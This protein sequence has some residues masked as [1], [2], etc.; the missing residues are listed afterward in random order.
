MLKVVFSGNFPASLHMFMVETSP[1]TVNCCHTILQKISTGI[2]PLISFK[3]GKFFRLIHPA[4]K[5][6]R[7]CAISII[8]FRGKGAV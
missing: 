8:T 3:H 4:N 1:F 2:R 5:D 7:S 6:K